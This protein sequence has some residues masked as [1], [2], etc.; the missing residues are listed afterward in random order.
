MDEMAE[1]RQDRHNCQKRTKWPKI[2]KIDII[3]KTGQNGRKSTRYTIV[4]NGR[5]YNDSCLFLACVLPALACFWPALSGVRLAS[6]WPFCCTGVV[7]SAR[8]TCSVWPASG[9]P[10][11]AC[12]V[13]VWPAVPGPR[14]ENR[15]FLMVPLEE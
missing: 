6:F 11:L 13:W 3:V 5:E 8:L 4:K 15:S 10:C 1:N 7:V 2:D 12:V 14:P 9:S